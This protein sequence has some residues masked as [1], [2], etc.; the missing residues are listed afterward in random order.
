MRQYSP[1]VAIFYCQVR[2]AF[3]CLHDAQIKVYVAA[4]LDMRVMIY[5]VRA[6]LGCA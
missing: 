5:L 3:R 1:F 2:T 4:L 6:S